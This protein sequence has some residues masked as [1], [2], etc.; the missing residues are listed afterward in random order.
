MALQIL[1]PCHGAG[2]SAP[3]GLQVRLPLLERLLDRAQL[4]AEGSRSSP[5]SSIGSHR[6]FPACVSRRQFVFSL[7]GS[8]VISHPPP[9]VSKSPVTACSVQVQAKTRE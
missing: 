8:C 6:F 1:Q 2:M 7:P 5:R 3:L 4:L 9:Y